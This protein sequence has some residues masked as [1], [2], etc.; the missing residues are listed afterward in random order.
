MDR[1]FNRRRGDRDFTQSMM[2]V[3]VGEVPACRTGDAHDAVFRS[4]G[5]ISIS[6]SSSPQRTVHL[7]QSKV[8]PF[9]GIVHRRAEGRRGGGEHPCCH[10]H[11]LLLPRHIDCRLSMF[12]SHV[13]TTP[14]V[15]SSGR[16]AGIRANLHSPYC[17]RSV[18]E[19]LMR[20]RPIM[21]LWKNGHKTRGR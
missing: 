17:T 9:G 11:I 20:R 3:V 18:E 8:V 15:R 14:A 5:V 1:D 2:Y 6:T 10:P 16:A 13:N 21:K 19:Y 7:P 4:M 12:P